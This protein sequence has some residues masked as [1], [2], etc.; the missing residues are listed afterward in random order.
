ML[1]DTQPLRIRYS[2]VQSTAIALEAPVGVEGLGVWNAGTVELSTTVEAPY[3][4][5]IASSIANGY[6]GRN[7]WLVNQAGGK[8]SVTAANSKSIAAY[9]IAAVWNAGLIQAVSTSDDASAIL[10][11]DPAIYGIVPGTFVNA[12][13]I[14]VDAAGIGRGVD[15][16][17]NSGSVVLM[18]NSG[19][20]SVHG[21]KA[22]HGIENYLSAHPAAEQ[23]AIVN[24][25]S[26]TVTDET[27]LADSAGL[28]L[29]V[30]SRAKVWNSG[31]ITADYAIKVFAS[32][33]YQPGGDKSLTVY[34]SGS[35]NGAVQLSAY[36]DILVNTS[37]IAG[38]VNLGSGS[39][40]Y[41]GRLGTLNGLLDGYDG[42]DTLLAGAGDQTILGGFGNDILSGGAG[43]DTLT[44]G[45]GKDRF[46]FGTGFGID[47][48]TDFAAGERIDVSG[49]SAYQSLAQQGA[50][51]IITF[52]A[53]D[54]VIVRNA[55]AA[56]LTGAIAFGVAEIVAATIPSAPVAATAP[57]APTFKSTTGTADDNSLIGDSGRDELLGLGGADNLSGLSGDDRLLGADGNDVLT[58]GTG[59]DLLIGGAGKDIA[60]FQGKHD[61]Y[62][63]EGL[64]SGDLR[65]TSKGRRYRPAGRVRDSALRRRRLC[66]ERNDRDAECHHPIRR[67]GARVPF[68]RIFRRHRRGCHRVRNTRPAGLFRPARRWRGHLRRVVQSRGRRDPATGQRRRL[69]DRPACVRRNRDQRH[70]HGDDPAWTDG[71]VTGLCRWRANA[72]LRFGGE[73]SK[74]RKPGVRRRLH[75]S[76][77]NTQRRPP[78]RS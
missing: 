10:G 7:H 73:H 55:T 29:N 77:G 46:R 51:V 4:A 23:P 28:L 24:S 41:D 72:G 9:G 14:I 38:S 13:S 43:N 53:T 69:Y 20:I 35:L 49:Y 76:H 61:I 18:V 44:G 75:D 12:G 78:P 11:L 56:S 19:Q 17:T 25:G 37:K 27:P 54:K 36:D 48:I 40:L 34:N 59:D 67:D 52:S 5:A 15:Q 45:A 57:P 74:D 1:G 2:T 64:S 6:G 60:V 30:A 21:G 3:S 33:S 47:T 8:L 63:I 62:A 70:H 65:V 58:G 66:L 42:D 22:S 32:S 68:G 16:G 26:I 71:A 50:D 31:T 39:D